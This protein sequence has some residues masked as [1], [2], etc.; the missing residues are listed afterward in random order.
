MG[1]NKEEHKAESRTQIY[2]FKTINQETELLMEIS[3]FSYYKGGFWKSIIIG[4]LDSINKIDDRKKLSNILII[5]FLL[6]TALIYLNISAYIR[7]EKT[8]L[9]LAFFLLLISLRILSTGEKL[10]MNFFPSMPWS[11]LIKLEFI[12]YYLA[13]PIFIMFL[14][15]FFKIDYKKN[16]PIIIFS[17]VFYLLNTIIVIFSQPIFFTHLLRYVNGYTFVFGLYFIYRTYQITYIE[18]KTGKNLLIG[19]MIL[20]STV[21]MEIFLVLTGGRTLRFSVIGQIIFIAILIFEVN[22]TFSINVDEERKNVNYFQEISNKES[23]TDLYNYRFITHKIKEINDERNNIKYAVAM[24]DIDD[25]KLLN[26]NYGHKKGDLVLKEIAII[27]KENT[28]GNDFVARYGGEEFLLVFYNTS[29]DDAY[30]VCEKIR[31]N[32]EIQIEK[33]MGIRITISGGLA[34]FS[35]GTE[36]I[37]IDADTLLYKAKKLGKNIIAK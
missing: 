32:V 16:N 20:L 29:L 31:K 27:L 30:Y 22:K 26:D 12:S 2:S 10:I 6:T 14:Y 28:R 19:T 3:N 37:I 23:L 8:F 18:G 5:G 13:I 24:L 36:D 15:S 4:D 25:F 17:I 1:K 34:E 33:R 9:F 21:F 7:E 35:P 11:L